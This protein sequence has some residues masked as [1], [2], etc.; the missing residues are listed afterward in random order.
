MST[1][2]PFQSLLLLHRRSFSSCVW[3]LKTA[4]S[5]FSVIP[6]FLRCSLQHHL[7]EALSVC[8]G[9]L[10]RIALP[11]SQHT[12]SLHS[13]AL[14]VAH[15]QHQQQEPCSLAHESFKAHEQ[16]SSGKGASNSDA[17]TQR[18]QQPSRME[19]ETGDDDDM[20][21]VSWFLDRQTER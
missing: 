16:Q 12:L 10:G 13:H 18:V 19:S 15:P 3:V 11:L 14:D 2:D 4:C 17:N 21:D 5:C 1:I 6:A 8:Q 9:A 7:S 20:D